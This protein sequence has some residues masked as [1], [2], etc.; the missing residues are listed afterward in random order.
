[1]LDGLDNDCDGVVDEGTVAFDDDRD[2]AS[3][4]AGD[5]DDSTAAVGPSAREVPDHRDNDCDGLLD[6]GSLWTDDDGDGFSEDAGDCDDTDPA[7]AP[8]LAD[9]N[10]NYNLDCEG[11][12]FGT[13]GDEDEDGWTVEDGDCDDTD[14]WRH[15]ERDEAC[16]ERDNDCDGE[17][18]EGC[19]APE[20][21]VVEIP[22]GGCQHGGVWG[23]GWLAVLLTR[24]RWTRR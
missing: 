10:G 22:E 23:L 14:G 11:W 7:V 18:D 13:A 17:V 19:P 15:P 4:F 1:V 21:V 5:C 6:E 9:D 20:T 24:R 12:A 3:E 2:G 16:D 8:D